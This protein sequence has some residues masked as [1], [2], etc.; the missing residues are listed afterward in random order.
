VADVPIIPVDGAAM[1]WPRKTANAVNRLI[2][3]RSHPFVQ[4]AA[5]PASPTEGQTYYD[6]TTHKART[7]DGTAWQ[8]LF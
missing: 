6:L 2:K 5:A 4:L 1:D 3:L 7:F 8:N